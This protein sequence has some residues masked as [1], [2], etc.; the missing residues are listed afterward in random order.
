[1]TVAAT[2]SMLDWLSASVPR[3]YGNF[4]NGE[5][6]KSPSGKTLSIFNSAKNS[7]L[8][9]RFQDSAETD[10]NQAV[11]A[12]NKAFKSWS[13]LPGPD[14]G[15]ILFRFADLLEKHVDELAYMLSAE[16]GKTLNEN[17]KRNI[18]RCLEN[19]LLEGGVRSRSSIF[20][21][22]DSSSISFLGI[23]RK[24]VCPVGVIL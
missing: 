12:A 9:A 3:K 7:Q 18:S 20:E 23:N 1:M 15:A 11:E 8:L 16:Q 2:S 13:K 22:T 17:D 5:W 4:I 6:V 21:T 14:R 24:V 19:A 10:V